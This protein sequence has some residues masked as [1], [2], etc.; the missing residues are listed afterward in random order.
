MYLGKF[1]IQ[2]LLPS[3]IC[4]ICATLG[5]LAIR[6]MQQF[7]KKV[8]VSLTINYNLKQKEMVGSLVNLLAVQS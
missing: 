6:I 7:P 2:K 4:T 1:V 8:I 3:K 5:G